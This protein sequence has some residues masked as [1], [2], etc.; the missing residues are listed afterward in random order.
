MSHLLFTALF[1]VFTM[2]SFTQPLKNKALLQRFYEEVYID[3]DMEVA[4]EL[5]APDFIS[6]DWP[7]GLQG[8]EGFR[9]YYESFK[10]AIPDARYEVKDMVAERDRVVVR[11]EM[12][13]SYQ[14]QFPGMDIEPSGQEITLKG[15]AI[16]RVEDSKLKERWVVS[17]IYGL[18][19]EVQQPAN[20]N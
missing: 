8:P 3:W 20:K 10:K 14:S 19:K 2:A 13:G 1:P 15:V 6:H 17:D 18:L 4:D 5:L 11:W 12:Q 7:Q 9:R 16:Y